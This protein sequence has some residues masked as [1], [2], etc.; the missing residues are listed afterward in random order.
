MHFF[1]L[2][3][4]ISLGRLL[5]VPILINLILS[6]EMVASFWVFSIASLSDALDGYLARKLK[7]RTELGSFLDPIADKALLISVYLSLGI[8]GNISTWLVTLVIF[9]DILIVGGTILL[10]IF[11]KP[12]FMNP[13]LSS[14]IN[15]VF[16]ILFI[17]FLLASKSFGFLS[18]LDY[19]LELF[20]F[21]VGL[22]TL[23]SGT[24]YVKLWLERINLP[25]L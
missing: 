6:N 7:I 25:S 5:S 20:E 8:I 22:T 16:Q 10:Y 4:F 14:K 13:I 15:T 3:N 21:G 1:N 19:L 12:I 23:L 9:R 2:P 11:Q 24:F 18:F 17:S